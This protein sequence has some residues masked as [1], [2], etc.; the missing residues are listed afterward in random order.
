[1]DV[2]A[3]YQ[4]GA[5]DYSAQVTKIAAMDP[6]PDVIFTPMFI[7]DT[8]VFLKQLRQTQKMAVHTTYRFRKT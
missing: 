2:S 4:I 8:P 6:A 3:Q 7:P 5:G 1:M